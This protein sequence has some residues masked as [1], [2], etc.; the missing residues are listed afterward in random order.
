[1]QHARQT[2]TRLID[3]ERASGAESGATAVAVHAACE[4][5]YRNLARWVGVSGARGLFVRAL[6]E[7][8][9]KHPMLSGISVHVPAAG[10]MEG[11]PESILTHGDT[12][13][14]AAL[15]SLLVAL[16]ALLTRLIGD[17]MVVKLLE[18]TELNVPRVDAGGAR[19]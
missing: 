15:D 10:A 9:P 17:D 4:R 18:P 13:V 8:Q 7:V 1:M 11:I 19:Q 12:P 6:S 14:A 3:R 16:L 5:V 2:A